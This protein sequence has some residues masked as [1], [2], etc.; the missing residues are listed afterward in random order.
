MKLSPTGLKFPIVFRKVQGHSMSPN[1]QPGWIVIGRRTRRVAFGD[2]VI[3]KKENME[4]VKRV[5]EVKKKKVHLAGDNHGHDGNH[6]AGW[7]PIED[8]VARVIWPRI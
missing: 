2:A 4:I 6:D 1:L 7:V 3:A 5:V 8:V